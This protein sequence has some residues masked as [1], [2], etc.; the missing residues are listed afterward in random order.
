[1]ATTAY[2]QEVE[3]K[4]LVEESLGLQCDIELGAPHRS[5]F[6][7][8]VGDPKREIEIDFLVP[9]HNFCVVGEHTNEK[10]REGVKNHLAKL[11][12]KIDFL[13]SLSKQSRFGPFNIP[14]KRR[15]AYAKVEKLTGCLIYSNETHDRPVR[16]THPGSIVT[17]SSREWH[18][19]EH[20]ADCLGREGKYHFLDAI[21]LPLTDI[22]A[23]SSQGK[24][25]IRLAL[26]KGEY[27]TLG[28]RTLVDGFP[29]ADVFVFA[30]DP[31]NLVP[32]SRVLR[33]DSLPTLV[34]PLNP[35]QL[36]KYQRVLIKKKLQDLRRLISTV[37]ST[38]AFPTAILALL[39]SDCRIDPT[40]SSLV[41]PKHFGTLEII[42]GQ[43]RVFAYA[44]ETIESKIKDESRLV[45]VG[46]KF[47][48]DAVQ[49]GPQ[50]AARMFVDINTKQTR[51]RRD[52][53]LII[54]YE[55][56]Q[57]EPEH[58]A[59]GML[60]KAND[61]GPLENRLYVG[62]TSPPNS[63]QINTIITR[64]KPMFDLKKLRRMSLRDKRKRLILLGSDVGIFEQGRESEYVDAMASCYRRF[65]VKISQTFKEDW[66]TPVESSL[67]S[68]KYFAAL[69]DRLNE[70]MRDGRNWEHIDLWMN[71]LKER[72][73][74]ISSKPF[75]D[76]KL[77]FSCD[78]VPTRKSS[79]KDIVDHL[80]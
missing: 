21:G 2:P 53:Q 66:S 52:L 33:R 22:V 60:L 28:K 23:H 72:S 13:N 54:A 50:W 62:A 74:K 64:L 4:S 1:M 8:S 3:V 32:I 75:R 15:T 35:D 65:F 7:N 17:M 77:A 67:L 78:Q 40:D 30:L 76:R 5:D 11:A 71:R 56:G 41:I 55:T 39:S 68:S 29:K 6:D 70:F 80:K 25:E 27:L 9:F 20:Y 10:S 63:I 37:G 31:A 14:P 34:D 58:L 38:F 73:L 24:P 46:V 19:A 48:S 26:K 51:V 59:A 47:E 69:T 45:V 57:Q 42:D 16:T 79:M 36:P 12:G 44:S 43:H 61:S 18:Q 49:N